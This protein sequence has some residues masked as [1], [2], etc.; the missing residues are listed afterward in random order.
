MRRLVEASQKIKNQFARPDCIKL[1]AH[2]FDQFRNLRRGEGSYGHAI[3][4]APTFAGNSANKPRGTNDKDKLPGRLQGHYLS[5]SR[6]AGPVNFIVFL[7]AL[8]Q[9]N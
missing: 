3:A 9:P 4:P 1:L 6:D 7:D 8:V 2:S 5:K